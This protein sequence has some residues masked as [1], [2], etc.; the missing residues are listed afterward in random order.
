MDGLG[1][2]VVSPSERFRWALESLFAGNQSR[3]AAVL[4]CSQP[5]V[6]RIVAGVNEPGKKLL[7]ALAAI[8]GV[9]SQWVQTGVGSPSVDR[10]IAV[11]HC[12]LPGIPD[13]HPSMLTDSRMTF[14]FEKTRTL[15]V[16]SVHAGMVIV[17]DQSP[18]I[19]VGESL[20][21]ETDPAAWV[22][23]LSSLHGRLC[24]VKVHSGDIQTLRLH[25]VRFRD[26][27][28]AG[29]GLE[30]CQREPSR[31]REREPRHFSFADQELEHQKPENSN[32]EGA[33][34]AE[35]RSWVPVDPAAIKGVV[36]FVFRMR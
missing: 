30:I 34:D 12:V 20:V 18:K 8:P 11:A 16:V 32:A 5:T 14:P 33:T 9:D 29:L 35:E 36:R 23:N 31:H 4:G 3:M 27:G 26:D 25:Q 17:D 6:S 15:Y 24:V 10:S 1:Q 19:R 7:A 13:L 2:E 21:I 22:H 28:G